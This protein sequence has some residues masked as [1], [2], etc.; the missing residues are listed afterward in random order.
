MSNPYLKKLSVYSRKEF[1]RTANAILYG[2]VND[3]PQLHDDFDGF[4][5]LAHTMC[6]KLYSFSKT[7]DSDFIMDSYTPS[8]EEWYKMIDNYMSFTLKFD[9]EYTIFA[10]RLAFATY[11]IPVDP[12]KISTWN[13]YQLKMKQWITGK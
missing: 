8:E 1:A 7:L 9:V 3:V 4:S 5:W 12:K 10:G 2:E 11:K 13:T 6:D